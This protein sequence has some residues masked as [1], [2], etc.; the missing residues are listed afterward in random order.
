MTGFPGRV[1]VNVRP[2]QGLA[3]TAVRAALWWYC[4]GMDGLSG[5]A[6]LSIVD[7]RVVLAGTDITDSVERLAFEIADEGAWLSFQVRA[8][9]DAIEFDFPVRSVTQ[10]LGG[11][12]KLETTPAELEQVVVSS[13]GYGTGVDASGRAVYDWLRERGVV[14]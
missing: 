2:G 6:R 5:K 3:S 11:G 12:G 9:V 7:G 10:H 13:L 1:G 4:A 8:E 14:A